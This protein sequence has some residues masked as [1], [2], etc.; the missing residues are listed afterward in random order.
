MRIVCFTV[1]QARN[2]A[3]EIARQLGRCPDGIMVSIVPYQPPKSR[4]QDGKIHAMISDL[5]DH[6]GHERDEMKEIVKA[7]FWPVQ[8]SAGPGGSEVAHAKSTAQLTRE[9]ASVV[10]ERLYQLAAEYGVTLKEDA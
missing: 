7:M 6:T 1:D 8:V 4:K 2:A 5:A 9:E 10:I 3:A